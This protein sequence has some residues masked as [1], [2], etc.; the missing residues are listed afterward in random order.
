M[1]PPLSFLLSPY[2]GRLPKRVDLS[3]AVPLRSAGTGR[4]LSG[5][6]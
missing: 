6:R 3:P 1:E 2:A 4:L 5:E